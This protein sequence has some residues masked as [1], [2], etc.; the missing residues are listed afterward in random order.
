MSYIFF[1]AVCSVSTKINA[2]VGIFP[3]LGYPHG[4]GIRRKV[5]LP[6]MARENARDW[7][8]THNRRHAR[9]ANPGS[10]QAASVPPPEIAD[11]H[12]HAQTVI[13]LEA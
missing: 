13:P 6:G 4:R 2:G 1:I 5:E 3:V 8:K 10:V 11:T 7:S 9:S 12:W